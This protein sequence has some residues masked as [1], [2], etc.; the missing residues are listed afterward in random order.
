MKITTLV[1]N[2]C[3]TGLPTEHGLSL[4]IEANGVRVLYDTGETEL[5]AENAE[6]LG[7][8]LSTADFCFLS[9]GHHDHGGGLKRFTEINDRAK[10]YMARGAF[11]LYYNMAGKYIGLNR[12]WLD[13]PAVQERIVYTDGELRLAEGITILPPGLKKRVD[14]GNAGMSYRE[15]GRSFPEV[16]RHEQYLLIEEGDKRVLISGCSHQ[17]IINIMDWFKPDVMIGGFHF[18]NMALDDKLLEFGRALDAYGAEYYTCHCTGEAQY[19][20]L[21]KVMK[22]LHYL[23][24]GDVL[25]I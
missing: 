8:D 3:S 15:G 9:H 10:I 5:F 24:E 25:E 18:M 14:M 21:R 11:G 13:D 7:V 23:A 19:E 16:F 22:R 6:K 4:F 2:T 17:G 1:E 12:S 20:C